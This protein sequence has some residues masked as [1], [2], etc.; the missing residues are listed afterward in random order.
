MEEC[1]N[2]NQN[3]QKHRTF[4]IDYFRAFDPKQ[5]GT[6]DRNNGNIIVE[7]NQDPNCTWNTNTLTL[8]TL[9]KNS[10]LCDGAVLAM[11]SMMCD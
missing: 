3:P 5:I 4:S 1:R 2:N 10:G 7:N 8:D 11:S 9:V 6:R